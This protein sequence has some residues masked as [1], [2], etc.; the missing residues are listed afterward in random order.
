LIA[1]AQREKRCLVT[2][3][4]EFGNPLLFDPTEHSGIVVIRL[5]KASTLLASPV[6]PSRA[7]PAREERSHERVGLG[8]LH[9][10]RGERHGDGEVHV[11]G[12]SAHA[13]TRA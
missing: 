13:V 6:P 3:D 11:V 9:R 8:R 1:V 10:E 7:S 4:L 2:F 5:S 12:I